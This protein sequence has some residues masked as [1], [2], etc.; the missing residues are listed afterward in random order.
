MIGYDI[1]DIKKYDIM[2]TEK[3]RNLMEEIRKINYGRV[4]V[5]VENGQPARI[6]EIQKSKKL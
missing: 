2:V 5:F 6:D 4:I 3:E 1:M